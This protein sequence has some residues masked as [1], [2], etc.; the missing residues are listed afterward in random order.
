MNVT[1]DIFK[2]NLLEEAL[3]FLNYAFLEEL[4]LEVLYLGAP[5]ATMKVGFFMAV[6]GIIS[7]FSPPEKLSSRM[8]LTDGLTTLANIAGTI[9]SAAIFRAIGYNGVFGIMTATVVLALA[10]NLL[11]VK[12]FPQGYVLKTSK[13]S[14]SASTVVGLLRSGLVQ[15]LVDLYEML[16]KP[17]R[18]RMRPLVMISILAMILYYSTYD[19]LAFF[20][21]YMLLRFDITPEDFSM[22]NF[23]TRTANLVMMFSLVPLLNR[24]LGWHESEMMV[25]FSA[26]GAAS[27]IASAFAASLWQFILASAPGETRF[28]C[29]PTGRSL[30]TNMVEP[31][32]VPKV[33]GF[34][35]VLVALVGL[36]STFLYRFLYDSTL[37]TYPS[38][39][40]LLSASIMI[41]S[42]VAYFMLMVHKKLILKFTNGIHKSLKEVK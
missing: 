28:L 1:I 36:G 29:Y 7:R 6:Y 18:Y 21:P 30:L 16:R 20:Y 9:P 26:V 37:R 4:P 25:L 27:L 32:E 31:E 41:L 17:R 11:F 2:G 38:A 24:V 19:D 34:L 12:N 13:E 3:N 14:R 22:F 33:Y 23:V 10:Y 40:L 15:P 8:A 39:F 5:I 42:G 35:N